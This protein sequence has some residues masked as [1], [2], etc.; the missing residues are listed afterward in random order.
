M[1][2]LTSPDGSPVDLTSDTI[3]PYHKAI[4]SDQIVLEDVTVAGIQA[5]APVTAQNAIIKGGTFQKTVNMDENSIIA[6][7]SFQQEVSANGSITGGTFQ[8]NVKASGTIT[9]GQFNAA[10]QLDSSSAQILGGVFNNIKLP[11][12]LYIGWNGHPECRAHLQPD[13]EY[14]QQGC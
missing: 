14:F 6:S 8:K 3:N 7:G 10:V 4:A 5:G 11:D 1:L 9:G 2:V 12:L 13:G